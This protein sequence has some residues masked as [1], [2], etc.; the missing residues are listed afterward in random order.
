MPHR[1]IQVTRLPALPSAQH[2]C[3]N[4]CLLPA[5]APPRWTVLQGPKLYILTLGVLAPYRGMGAGSALL[6][7]CLEVVT[8]QLPEVHEAVL[9]V[10]VGGW[11]GWVAAAFSLCCF[12]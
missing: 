2:F 1:Q 4:A 7:K 8:T 11:V 6:L 12:M 10:Q 3:A 5:T 9:H